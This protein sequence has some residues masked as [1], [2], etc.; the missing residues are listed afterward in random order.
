MGGH[1]KAGHIDT[2]NAHTVNLFG[3]QIK[4][5][6]GGGRYAQV[7]YHYGIVF[8]GIGELVY[9]LT[10][11]LEQLSCN[12]GFRVKRH[13]AHSAPGAVEVGGEGQPVNA[14]GRATQ[15]GGRATHAQADSQGSK[16]W[17]HTLGLVVGPHRVVFRVL[18]QSS[19][20]GL[21]GRLVT[22]LPAAPGATRRF[23]LT[24]ID[25]RNRVLHGVVLVRHRHKQPLVR[26]GQFC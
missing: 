1:A 23:R 5:H 25:Q 22:Q 10:D 11:V 17:A 24:L 4:G 19:L 9:G 14:T 6:A 26:A 15:D 21:L 2:D 18:V 12:Q 8:I 16:G 7:N 20:I 3:Q 13:V